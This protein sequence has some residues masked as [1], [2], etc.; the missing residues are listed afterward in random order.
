MGTTF[1]GTEIFIL[2]HVDSVHDIRNKKPSVHQYM[3]G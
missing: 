1:F 3:N 2:K